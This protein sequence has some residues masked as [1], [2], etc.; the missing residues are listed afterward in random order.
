MVTGIYLFFVGCCIGSFVNVLIYRLPLNKS[1]IYPNSR[2]PQ[3]NINIK[4]FDNI[5]LLS[6]F[7]L[8]GKCRVCE[9]KISFSYPAV[10]FLVGILVWLNI[11]AHPTI[12]S[13]QPISVRILFGIIFCTLLIPLAIL[14]FKYF[15]LPKALTLAGLILGITGSLIVDLTN[16]FYQFN[17]SISTIIASFLGFNFFVLLSFVGKKIYNKPVMGG[18]DAKLCALIGS[19]LGIQGLFISIWLAFLSAGIFVTCGLILKKI[20]RNQKIPFGVFLALS[21]LLVWYFGN[22]IFLKI[23]FL[24]I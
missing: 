24:Q 2:C 1:I 11:Y 5:P 22:Q 20:K 14:D 13:Q 17:Y 3:C 10:E 4:W 21:G 18:G 6:W 15:W 19:W 9:T 23:L 12:Y 8:R 16:D 7:I